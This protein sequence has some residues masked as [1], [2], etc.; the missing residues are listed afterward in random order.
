MVT[1]E[2]GEIVR[3]TRIAQALR[4]ED[5][6]A[7]TGVS[8]SFISDLENGKETLQIGKALH[9]LNELGVRLTLDAPDYGNATEGK[10]RHR[11]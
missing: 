5:L 9:V 8:V 2:I 1:T 3:K 11:P 10:K 7:A 6:A 4:M